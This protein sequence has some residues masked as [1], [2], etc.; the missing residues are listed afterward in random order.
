MK[1]FLAEVAIFFSY[2]KNLIFL[3]AR[4]TIAYG[5]AMPALVKINN[6]ESTVKWF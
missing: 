6:F 4:L 3:A 2:P 5:F 1:N